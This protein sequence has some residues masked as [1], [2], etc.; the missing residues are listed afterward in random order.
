MKERMKLYGY[1]L[2]EH[3]DEIKGGKSGSGSNEK[4]KVVATP[5]KSVEPKK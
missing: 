3:L 5:S 4:S 2:Q 1:D